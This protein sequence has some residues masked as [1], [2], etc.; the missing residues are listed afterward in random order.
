MVLQAVVEYVLWF[1]IAMA[2]AS[3]VHETDGLQQLLND[4]TD[5]FVLEPSLAVQDLLQLGVGVVV[6][7]QLAAALLLVH[8]QIMRLNYVRV[9]KKLQ[10]LILSF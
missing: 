9:D 4:F 1:D 6:Q 2:D 7:H 8:E 3:L 5:F 10:N